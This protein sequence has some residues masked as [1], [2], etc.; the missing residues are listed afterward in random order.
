MKSQGKNLKKN[1]K[2][3]KTGNRKFSIK[4]RLKTINYNFQSKHKSIKFIFQKNKLM[5]YT[6]IKMKLKRGSISA[7]NGDCS[8]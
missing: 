7:A 1:V 2:I 6:F 5:S 4:N 8:I 3:I